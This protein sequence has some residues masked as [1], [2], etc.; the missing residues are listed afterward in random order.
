VVLNETASGSGSCVA[1]FKFGLVRKSR[2]LPIVGD[3]SS[4]DS[5][6]VSAPSRS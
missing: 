6:F 4:R 3:F 1:F 2:L 5:Y